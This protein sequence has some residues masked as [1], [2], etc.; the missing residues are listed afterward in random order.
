MLFGFR[1]Y[2]SFLFVSHLEHKWDVHI[3]VKVEGC[4]G[5][6]EDMFRREEI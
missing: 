6:F 4:K 3:E 1:V 2:L 5:Y